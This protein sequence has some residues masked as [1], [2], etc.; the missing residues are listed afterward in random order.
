MSYRVSPSWRDASPSRR[1]AATPAEEAEGEEPQ[2][3]S[4]RYGCAHPA[5]EAALA[6]DHTT[7]V[8]DDA[9]ERGDLVGRDLL[10]GEHGAIRVGGQT[11]AGG[12]R[13]RVGHLPAGRGARHGAPC[14]ES[15]VD[16]L[17]P[18]AGDRAARIGIASTATATHGLGDHHRQE[19]AEEHQHDER[20]DAR[21]A[22]HGPEP[23]EVEA[24]VG[25]GGVVAGVVLLHGLGRDDLFDRVGPHLGDVLGVLLL[26]DLEARG[27]LPLRRDVDRRPLAVG[28]LDLCPRGQVPRSA[29]PRV[30]RRQGR[31]GRLQPCADDDAGGE[32]QFAGDERRGDRE[33]LVVADGGDV[34][35]RRLRP[36]V[37]LAVEQP[38]EHAVDAREGVTGRARLQLIAGEVGRPRGSRGAR[39]GEAVAEVPALPEQLDEGLQG[40][41]VG[42]GRVL[43]DPSLQVVSAGH[44]L[45]RSGA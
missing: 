5:P 7:L 27:L 9:P 39:R 6:G 2:E 28:A 3:R 35:A 8:V 44:P 43:F 29:L 10:G 14:I 42:S 16:V 13:E 38:L 1:D 18:S 17:V 34:V 24:L 30:A 33:L 22:Q 40:C 25:A 31:I 45:R 41:T 21:D 11:D 19:G 32:A 20:T 36:R 4:Q 15:G 37:V 23:G 26:G 12:R